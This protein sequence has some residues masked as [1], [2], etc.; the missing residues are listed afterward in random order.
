[1]N[2]GELRRM[3]QDA[4]DAMQVEMADGEGPRQ[5]RRGPL[6]AHTREYNYD[7]WE[8]DD[9]RRL[10]QAGDEVRASV[11]SRQSSGLGR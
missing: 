6:M 3:V 7:I 5:D 2:V 9:A 10:R 4:P 8:P 11:L 1:M